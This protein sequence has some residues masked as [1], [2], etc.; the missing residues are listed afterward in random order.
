MAETI[1]LSRIDKFYGGITIG[2]KDKREGVCLNIEEWDIFSNPAYMEPETI[3]T[4]D[5]GQ[6]TEGHFDYAFDG[7]DLYA[8]GQDTSSQI[9]IWK[10]ASAAGSNPGNWASYDTGTTAF[11]A[12]EIP[13]MLFHKQTESSTIK[14]YLYYTGTPASGG[15][16]LYRM[17]D[18]SAAG[19]TESTTDVGAT[20]M[21]MTGITTALNTTV[22]RPRIRLFDDSYFGHGRY[23]AKI[24]KSGVFTEKAFTLPEGWYCVDFAGVGDTIYILASNVAE[25]NTSRIFIWDLV[26][27]TTFDDSIDIPMG[28]AQ[29]ILNHN[30]AVRVW[31]VQNGILRIY[32]LLGKIPKRTHQLTNVQNTITGSSGKG[33]GGNY[34]PV[35]KQFMFIKD[36]VVY[37]G[38]WKSD[39][40][41][42]YAL[43]QVEDDKPLA[44]VLSR[45]FI[46]SGT[47]SYASL[48]PMAATVVANN[49][50]AAYYNYTVTDDYQL[51]RV[52]NDNSPT[53]SSDSVYE[54]IWV[55]N[56]TVEVYK[57]W[58]GIVVI[59]KPAPA[60]TAITINVRTDNASAYNTNSDA[61]PELTS[62]ND[63]THDGT[64]DLTDG[65]DT[66]WYREFTSVIGRAI[67]LKISATSSTT[68]KVTIYSVGLLYRNGQII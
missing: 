5:N 43:G 46:A 23:V 57:D 60:S 39:K 29:A 30:E 13:A 58:T 26:A 64:T 34:R 41:G 2:D 50:F 35:M 27:A 18:I 7:T 17:G 32:E 66:F 3:L 9:K 8:L 63:Q 15:L 22:P 55:D 31:C 24:D 49:I 12:Q 20:A 47:A 14:T 54:S 44:L 11:D 38:L 1:E 48:R 61:I 67:Q 6:V 42:L 10:L 56:G 65:A 59:G 36:N 28:G 53:R 25:P 52:E 45:R 21:L 51:S 16:Q 19:V 40:S 68:S 4:A 33:D 37:F 62:A